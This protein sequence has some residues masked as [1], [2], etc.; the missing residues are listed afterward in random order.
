MGKIIS[1]TPILIPR[2]MEGDSYAIALLAAAGIEIG[3]KAVKEML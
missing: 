1:K 3:Y 2:A